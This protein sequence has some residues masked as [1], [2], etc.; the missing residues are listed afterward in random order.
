MRGGKFSPE[1]LEI[2]TKPQ[3]LWRI[4]D[5]NFDDIFSVANNLDAE[6]NRIKVSCATTHQML[7][8]VINLLGP[9]GTGAGTVGS[10][11]FIGPGPMLAEDNANFYFDNATNQLEMGAG[12]AGTPSYSFKGDPNTGIFS[13]AADA[14][15]ISTGGTERIRITNAGIICQAAGA[16]IDLNGQDLILDTDGDTYLH[17]VVDDNIRLQLPNSYIEFSEDAS[18]TSISISTPQRIAQLYLGSFSSD[19]VNDYPSLFFDKSHSDTIDTGAETLDNEILG[20]ITARGRET[21]GGPDEGAR[22]VFEQDGNS[23]AT[24]V[25]GAIVFQNSDGVTANLERLR[26]QADGEILATCAAGKTI[27]LGNVVW[28]DIRITPGSFDRPGITDPTMIA[29][30]VNGGGVSTYLYQ[31]AKTQFASFTVQLPHSYKTGTDIYAHIH[32]TPGPNGATES[33]RNVG[34]K[35][36]ISWANI[37]ANFPTMVEYDLRDACDGTN[38]KHQMTP[39]V[40]IDGH[41]VA[42]GISSM[43]ICNVKRTDTGSDDAWVGIVS[44]ALPMILEIDFHFEIDTIGSRQQLVK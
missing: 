32:W 40:A 9:I 24:R 5:K 22:I 7:L 15:G 44:G 18:Y 13:A 20:R 42:K 17:E 39:D 38:H 8:S 14:I 27:L 11:V 36:D 4:T 3:D 37:D 28:D 1:R 16:N 26:I 23:T 12:A 6:D 33:G 29:Y 43:L 10:V 30:N 35:L 41:T 31:F 19:G 25:P 2:K 34:W 21:D